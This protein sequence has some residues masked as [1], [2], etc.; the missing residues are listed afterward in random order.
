MIIYS[1]Q[2][3]LSEEGMNVSYNLVKSEEP[4]SPTTQWM[5]NMLHRKEITYM[6]SIG[7]A[8]SIKAV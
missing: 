3:K 6:H 1:V 7:S 4:I 8:I 5:M 2:K